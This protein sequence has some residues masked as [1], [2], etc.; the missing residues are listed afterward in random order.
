ML[1]I[2]LHITLF[3][4]SVNNSLKNLQYKNKFNKSLPVFVHKIPSLNSA[5][6]NALFIC[7]YWKQIRP[8]CHKN[9][10]FSLS[11]KISLS[12]I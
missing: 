12:L 3:L 4:C 6:E 9:R 1:L 11:W 10:I 8:S 5:T 2:S 7:L